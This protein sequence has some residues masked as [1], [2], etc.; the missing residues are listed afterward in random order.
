[1]TAPRPLREVLR[2]PHAALLPL[3]IGFGATFLYAGLD[4]LLDPSFLQTTG[5]TS[6]GVQMAGWVYL[7][8][9]GGLVQ[10][11]LPY[12]VP[13]GLAI[14][15]GEVAIGLGALLGLAYRLAAFGGM[16]LSLLFF[17]TA[18][19]AVRPFY[20]GNDLPYAL[21]WATLLVAGTGGVLALDEVLAARFDSLGALARQ[22]A[23]GVSLPPRAA[24]RK[25]S[26]QHAT[27]RARAGD[28]DVPA[29]AE[30]RAILTAAALGALALSVASVA[31]VVEVA[32]GRRHSLTGGPAS[33]PTPAPTAI[34]LG[35]PSP[36]PS[37]VP[38]PTPVPVPSQSPGKLLAR[39][40]DMT[41]SHPVVFRDPFTSDPGV[42]L[43]L[44]DG[45]F[46]AYDAVCTHA[47]CTVEFDDTTGY[48]VCPCH[49]AVFDPARAAKAI[50]GPTF[51]PLMAFP[52][53]VDTA[54]GTIRLAAE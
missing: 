36:A 20:L 32:L 6:I 38:S 17:L 7:S 42:L 14:A 5:R 3:R 31:T 45:R 48:L 46:V 1:V 13:I 29:S 12:A 16:L 50:D 53:V 37:V 27:T 19:W 33:S 22:S 44:A 41:A 24:R 54:A 47:G 15:L 26:H 8:P 9:I 21:G 40:A 34:A 2:R 52:I 30:R 39:I 23:P 11:A 49:S 10:L 43:K 28:V 4:K 18:S 25:A 35:S 51:Q